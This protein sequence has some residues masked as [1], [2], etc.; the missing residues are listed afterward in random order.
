[1]EEEEEEVRKK[2][3]DNGDDE[4]FEIR[5][6][7]EIKYKDNRDNIPEDNILRGGYG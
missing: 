3:L 1:M 6:R 5:I 2:N 7:C 4:F